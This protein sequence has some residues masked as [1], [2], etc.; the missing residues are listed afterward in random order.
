MID[1]TVAKAL[2]EEIEQV[3]IETNKVKRQAESEVATKLYNTIGIGPFKYKD[4]IYLLDRDETGM[5]YFNV[6][7]YD[8]I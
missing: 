8:T 6:T 5:L 3:M 1:K 7:E 4:K 2:F